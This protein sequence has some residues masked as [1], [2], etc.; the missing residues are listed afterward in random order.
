M[1]TGDFMRLLFF[2]TG[3]I[4]LLGITWLLSVKKKEIKLR[5]I[6]W[7]LGLQFAFGL[8]VMKWDFGRWCLQK[9]AD[10]VAAFLDF[11]IEGSK[12]LFDRLAM[13]EYYNIFG[14]Q[15]AIRVLPTIIFFASFIA[16][17]YHYGIMQRIVWVM[18]K[19]M[20][21][22]MGT[23]G[24]ESLS[25]AANVFVGQTE[26]P[27]IVKPYI[28]TMTM[29]EINAVMVGGFGTIAGG[30]MAGII[31]MGVN[32]A[33]VI[34]A[35]LMAAPASLMVA[36]ILYPETEESN[37]AKEVTAELN[38]TSSNGIEAAANGA[39]DG[40]FLALNVAGMLIAFVSLIAVINALLGKLDYL[41]DYKLFGCILD[42][43]TNEYMGYFPGSLRTIFSTLLYP[44]AWLMGVPQKDCGIFSYLLGMKIS[45]NEF[46]AY[47]ELIKF[48][49]V[50]LPQAE[51][52]ATQ[53]GGIFASALPA[54][55]L[56]SVKAE[57]MATFALCGF[58][59]FA[60]IA[61]QIGGIS[62]MVPEN[63][64]E[65]L[66]GKL[67]RLGVRAMFG[68]AIVSCLTATIAGLLM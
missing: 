56:L 35:S 9:V 39:H 51:M 40:L 68:G 53:A 41:I 33:Y 54:R 12:F 8:L 43:S 22:T 65:E 14:Y 7:G 25:C 57:T 19:V 31:G 58:A 52:L 6:L 48:Q 62:P 17:L 55:E 15:W 50:L 37:T 11:S 44:L 29:S 60:S 23:S 18:A 32:P 30:V 13:A 47:M 2:F 46:V 3:I 20:S 10:G 4:T 5:P 63:Q 66:R 28:G 36:K 21:K 27:L 1:F 61:I 26:A 34:T 67:S 49:D 24:S 16:I 42:P 59:N 45:L 38:I 64:Q